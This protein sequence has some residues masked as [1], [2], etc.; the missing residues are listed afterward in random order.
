MLEKISLDN[1]SK[2]YGEN[3]AITFVL[4]GISID[5][6]RKDFTSIIGPSGSG[7]STLLSILATLEKPT[8]GKVFFDNRDILK[9]DSKQL[10]ELRNKQIS[11]IFQSFQLI[12]T[13]TA[14]ENV[15]VPIFFQ[16]TTFNKESRGKELLSLVG[17]SDKIHSLPSQ[18]SGGQQQ[19]VAIARALITE[20]DWIFADEPTGNL[21]SETSQKIFNLLYEIKKNNNCGIIMVTHESSLV[22]KSN[23]IVELEDGNIKNDTRLTH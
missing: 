16:K 1:I 22:Q 2:R 6:Y 8:E 13:L 19:R 5:F 21:D 11:F 9:L 7:K 18:L 20:P 10:A 4:K 23:R 17:L 3:D 14:L 12:P 15:L